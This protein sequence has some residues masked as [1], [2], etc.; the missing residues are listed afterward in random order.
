MSTSDS[1]VTPARQF[2]EALHEGARLLAERG[3]VPG[4]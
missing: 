4:V 3:F 1:L 2:F